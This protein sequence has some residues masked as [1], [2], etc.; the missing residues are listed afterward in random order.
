MKKKS[1]FRETQKLSRMLNEKVTNYGFLY[2]HSC[3][4]LQHCLW[5][6]WVITLIG[7]QIQRR[8]FLRLKTSKA[9]IPSSVRFKGQQ[10][11]DWMSSAMSTDPVPEVLWSVGSAVY[12]R[13]FSCQSW[14]SDLQIKT[15]QQIHRKGFLQGAPLNFHKALKEFQL[16]SN[17]WVSVNEGGGK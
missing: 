13:T 15:D 10:C 16:T 2:K 7:I 12:D 14:T 5:I 6:R 17:L 3:S 1:I 9:F 8:N 4:S 11:S